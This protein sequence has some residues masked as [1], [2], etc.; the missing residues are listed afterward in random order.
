[1]CL[2][3]AFPLRLLA[4]LPLACLPYSLISLENTNFFHMMLDDAGNVGEL[5]ITLPEQPTHGDVA[6]C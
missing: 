6:L 4:F 5:Y 1:V 2:L 3:K